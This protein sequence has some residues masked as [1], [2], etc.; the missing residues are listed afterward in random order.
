LESQNLPVGCRKVAAAA[1]I[2]VTGNFHRGSRGGGCDPSF[3]V[4]ERNL[5]RI[6]GAKE[7][8]IHPVAFGETAGSVKPPR[9]GARRGSAAERAGVSVAQQVCVIC[10]WE[11]SKQYNAK[12]QTLPNL[13]QSMNS[14]SRCLVAQILSSNRK[15]SSAEQGGK[16]KPYIHLSQTAQKKKQRFPAGPNVNVLRI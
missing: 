7:T 2:S 11:R 16:I 13:L 9:L 1:S 4:M 14:S 12:F 15:K 5:E 3:A 10:I 6:E 8:G